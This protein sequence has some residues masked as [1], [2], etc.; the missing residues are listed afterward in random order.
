FKT[1]ALS[2]LAAEL[3]AAA[4]GATES[5]TEAIG[6]LWEEI[7]VGFQILDDVR[8]LVKGNPGKLRGDDIVEGKK[9]L[10]VLI[11]GERSAD[12]GASLLAL[13]ERVAEAHAAKTPVQPLIE[14]AIAMME[15]S[16]AL[17]AASREGEALLD[18]ARNRLKSAWPAG[19]A[20]AGMED[21][22]ETFWEGLKP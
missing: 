22:I 4:A 14:Q 20:R 18:G 7:G 11:H 16:G 10:P 13:F 3:G 1:G 6:D 12:L 9:S 21:L 15:A 2:R 19:E 8:N 5:Q 17:S